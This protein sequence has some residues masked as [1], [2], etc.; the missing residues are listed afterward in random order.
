M[1]ALRG[2]HPRGSL[3]GKLFLHKLLL[4]SSFPDSLLPDS[5]PL[6]SLPLGSPLHCSPLLDGQLPCSPLPDNQLQYTPLLG[7]QLL[8]NRPR[9]NHLLDN[10]NPLRE[11]LLASPLE[12]LK[13]PKILS[14]RPVVTARLVASPLPEKVFRPPMGG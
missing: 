12:T 3:R 4:D 11:N 13:D 14:F 7:S 8:D 6:G 5:L 9:G 2:N 10:L 1:K